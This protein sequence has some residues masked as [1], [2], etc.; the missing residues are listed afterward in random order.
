MSAPL[1]LVVASGLALAAI[2]V[3]VMTV[4]LSAFTGCGGDGGTP[5]AMPGSTQAAWCDADL[6]YGA[7]VAPI[8]VLIGGLVGWR[9]R[10]WAPVACG[11]SVS[12]VV[13]LLPLLAGIVLPDT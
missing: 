11:G 13:A 7:F 12:L 6:D 10:R 3:A 5:Y 8:P 1:V 4:S 2:L 9:R